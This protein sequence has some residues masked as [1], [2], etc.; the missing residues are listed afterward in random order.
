[1]M[2]TQKLEVLIDLFCATVLDAEGVS[3]FER[4]RFLFDGHIL[5]PERTPGENGMEDGD[6]VDYYPHMYG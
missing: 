6:E 4:G 3:I 5:R 2:R 1:M